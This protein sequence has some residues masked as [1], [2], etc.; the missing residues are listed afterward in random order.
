MFHL[1]VFLRS[2]LVNDVQRSAINTGGHFLALFFQVALLF[3]T[4]NLFHIITFRPLE[5]I[6]CYALLL[7]FPNL[8]FTYF[9]Y[10]YSQLRCL[11]I[12]LILASFLFIFQS[13]D[14]NFCFAVFMQNNY[15]ITN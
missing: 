15:F 7:S 14:I 2:H 10:T 6:A 13:K 11:I 3:I 9:N 12:I 5:F 4:C 1:F 8:P